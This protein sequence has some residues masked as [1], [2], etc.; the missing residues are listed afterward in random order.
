M[1]FHEQGLQAKGNIPTPKEERKLQVFGDE[2]TAPD[3]APSQIL[4]IKDPESPEKKLEEALKL[5]LDARRRSAGDA[6]SQAGLNKLLALGNNTYAIGVANIDRRA[7]GNK[8][9]AR[10]LYHVLDQ[11]AVDFPENT[12]RADVQSETVLAT[13]NDFV[14][15][16][17][18]IK[19]DEARARFYK[20]AIRETVIKPAPNNKKD[21][22]K[23][24][25]DFNSEVDALN[26]QAKEI[27]S[28][29]GFNVGD[30]VEYDGATWSV[31]NIIHDMTQ[32]EPA[33]ILADKKLMGMIKDDESLSMDERIMMLGRKKEIGK[34]MKTL[35]LGEIKDKKMLKPVSSDTDTLRAVS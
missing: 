25:K 29:M 23:E 32:S 31:Y 6:T 7:Q 14:Q 27:F 3:L 24:I 20:S 28:L 35:W 2:P 5:G 17:D 9:I 1:R 18:A 8:E 4:R 26:K 11:G 19:D 15:K 30:R 13:Y 16:A 10:A 21:D 34:G 33:I 22:V 12:G